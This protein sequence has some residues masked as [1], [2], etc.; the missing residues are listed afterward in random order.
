MP[1]KNKLKAL[2]VTIDPEGMNGRDPMMYFA[3]NESAI[4]LTGTVAKWCKKFKE[5]ED[6]YIVPAEL[7]NTRIRSKNGKKD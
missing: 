4:F 5:T 3:P 7:W 1:K 2:R 6:F